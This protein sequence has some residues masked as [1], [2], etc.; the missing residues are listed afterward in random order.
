MCSRARREIDEGAEQPTGILR[1]RHARPEGCSTTV[2]VCGEMAG[3]A[4]GEM[5]GQRPV[6]RGEAGSSASPTALRSC[7]PS[8]PSD[9]ATARCSVGPSARLLGSNRAT[10]PPPGSVPTAT[11]NLHHAYAGQEQREPF[12]AFRGD[13]R[14]DIAAGVLGSCSLR[15]WRLS[16]YSWSPEERVVRHIQRRGLAFGPRSTLA[17]RTRDPARTSTKDKSGTSTLSKFDCR[18]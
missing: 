5:A 11:S 16:Q 14:S 9:A 4:C 15:D 8:S 3:S 7:R 2:H 1:G 17:R 13:T 12:V 10:S 18:P 6:R